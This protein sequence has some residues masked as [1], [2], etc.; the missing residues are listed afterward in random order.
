MIARFL[1]AL[2]ALTAALAS[3]V[4][5]DAPSLPAFPEVTLRFAPRVE[6]GGPRFTVGDLARAEGGAVA[7][8]EALE[9]LVLGQSPDLG[10]RL[11]F[12]ASQLEGMLRA[13]GLESREAL[14]DLPPRVLVE[15]RAMQLDTERLREVVREALLDELEPAERA[16]ASIDRIQLPGSV[17]LPQGDLDFRCEFRL[18]RSRT[19]SVPFSVELV[20]DGVAARKVHGSLSLDRMVPVLEAQ[21]P[22]ARGEAIAASDLRVAERRASEIRGEPVDERGLAAMAGS[23]AGRLTARRELDEGEIL[24]WHN[25][26]R[27]ML[28]LRGQAVRL[29]LES[30]DG[31]RITTLGRANDNGGLGDLV[32]VTNARSGRKVYGVVSGKQIVTVQF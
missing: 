3:P 29:K 21:R 13:A 2:F 4:L 11:T 18:P 20:V 25:V 9:G 30:D 31:M 27:E 10:R 8:R 22:V 15:R 28:V 32:E 12:N 17:D 19:G 6:V 7:E 26:Q 5:A 14:L 24:T 1:I 23:Q 16:D